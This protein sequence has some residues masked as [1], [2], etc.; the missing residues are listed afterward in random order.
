MASLKPGT[1]TSV[2]VGGFFC[3]FDNFVANLGQAHFNHQLAQTDVAPAI[4][5]LQNQGYLKNGQPQVGTMS[6]SWQYKAAQP[7]AGLV[8]QEATYGLFIWRHEHG[9]FLSF[10]WPSLGGR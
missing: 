1:T 8:M 7:D 3:D 9:V 4:R 10:E 2:D 6:V 5:T